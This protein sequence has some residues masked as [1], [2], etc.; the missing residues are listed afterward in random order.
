[1]TELFVGVFFWVIRFFI[2]FRLT[3]K[4]NS[5]AS[6]RGWWKSAVSKVV[7]GV[8]GERTRVGCERNGDAYSPRT[9]QFSSHFIIIISRRRREMHAAVGLSDLFFIFLFIYILYRLGTKIKKRYNSQTF[10]PTKDN[11]RARDDRRTVLPIISCR[12]TCIR[13]PQCF[14]EGL[15]STQCCSTGVTRTKDGIA[16][17]GSRAVQYTF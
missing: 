4:K 6:W 2:L 8:W 11:T 14:A 3:D 12:E 13:A 15:V 17:W 1:M 5:T 16:N 9:K 10:G 7:I